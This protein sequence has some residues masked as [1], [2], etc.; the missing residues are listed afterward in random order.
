MTITISN[1]MVTSLSAG[2]VIAAIAGCSTAPAVHR[3]AGNRDVD[4]HPAAVT[5]RQQRS[6]HGYWTAARM[7]R[8][9]VRTGTRGAWAD[10][11]TLGDGL[12]W[13]HGGAVTRTTGKVF[14]TLGGVDYVCSGSV[15]DGARQD[16]VL[17]AAHCTGNGPGQWASNWTFVPG[18]TGGARPY[19]TYSARKFYVSRRWE[20]EQG[21]SSARAEE[22]DVA[23][24]T[25]NASYGRRLGAGTGG[26]PASFS[27][28]SAGAKL[29]G[30]DA[31]VFG[32]PSDTPFNGLYPDYCAGRVR[33]A[34]RG[35]A[36]GA[37]GLTCAMTAGDSGGPWFSR[38]SPPAGTGTIVGVSTY[39][40]GDSARTL[41]GTVLGPDARALYQAAA[42]G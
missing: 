22:Y 36:D 3:A 21:T 26:Q 37:P 19:G 1:R 24:V 17:T 9:R 12:R 34:P 35:T 6:V 27:D 38:F 4:S 41:Y 2:L 16:V 14:F 31:Y 13:T 5:E 33:Q 30:R 11:N 39:K 7:R 18:Y 29:N 15:V 40:Y 28:S 42:R 20:T 25:V 10:G 8:A 23:F 32:Y